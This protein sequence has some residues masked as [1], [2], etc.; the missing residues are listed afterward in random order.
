M[1]TA[2][3]SSP[4]L[5]WGCL[6]A[7][8]S[9]ATLF[10]VF[11]LAS[12]GMAYPVEFVFH[13]LCGWIFY[14][15]NTLPNVGFNLEMILCGLGALGLAVWLAHCF[16][17]WLRS[18]GDEHAER[19][20]WPPRATLACAS[21][22]LIM[23]GAAIAITGIVHQTGWLL[24][25][26]MVE[27]SMRSRG[28]LSKGLQQGTQIYKGILALQNDT[29][30]AP[31]NLDELLVELGFEN[32]AE[33]RKPFNGPLLNGDRWLYFP[34]AMESPNGQQVVLV[35]PAPFAGN[36]VVIRADGSADTPKTLRNL[37][38]PFHPAPALDPMPAA[39]R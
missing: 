23:F 9:I 17:R 38:L 10:M 18:A 30:S 31:Q 36:W 33:F 13:A 19:K 4:N 37:D 20:P 5:R 22:L 26:K 16:L 24:R 12:V 27:S 29:G 6:T 11:I 15:V 39:E 28:L 25:D 2:S 14:L 7:L 8:A 21:L 3:G 35:S 34:D 32:L 1:S